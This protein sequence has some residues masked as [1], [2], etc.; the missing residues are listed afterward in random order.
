MGEATAGD[1]SNRADHP[2]IEDYPRAV[3]PAPGE[4]PVASAENFEPGAILGTVSQIIDQADLLDRMEERLPVYFGEDAIAHPA[5]LLAM[6]NHA[7]LSNYKLGPWIHA[8]SELMNFDVARAKEVIEAR[9]RIRECFER[10][11]HQFVTLD[12]LLLAGDNRVIQKV[13]HTAIYEIKSGE[14]KA[15]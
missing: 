2:R 4:R 12:V 11:G 6:S 10:K 7:L 13:L 15:V 9:S 8:A 1:R 3:L 14:S 5:V